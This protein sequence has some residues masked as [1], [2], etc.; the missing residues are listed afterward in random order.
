M[1]HLASITAGSKTL[2]TDL[3]T[4]IIFTEVGVVKVLVNLETASKLNFT[5]DGTNFFPVND[6]ANLVADGPAEFNIP[7]R[8]GTVLNFQVDT[9]GNVDF[10][11]VYFFR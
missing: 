8:N 4:D 10:L 1:R 6:N 7:V 2:N 11:D 5:L 3:I 9:T